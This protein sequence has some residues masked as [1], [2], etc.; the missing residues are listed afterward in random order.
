M[1][2][3]NEQKNILEQI[4]DFIEKQAVK[5]LINKFVSNEKWKLFGDIIIAIICIISIIVSAKWGFIEKGNVSSLLS[6]VIGAVI[7]SRFKNS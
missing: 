7:G 2:E 4:S 3:N 6:L 1:E 5:D